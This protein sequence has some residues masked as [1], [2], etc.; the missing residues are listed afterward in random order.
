MTATVS[1]AAMSRLRSRSTSCGPKLTETFFNRSTGSLTLQAPGRG[2][3]PDHVVDAIREHAEHEVDGQYCHEGSDERLGGRPADAFGA[4][5]AVEAA[6]A[7]DQRG[8]AAED[9][10]FH[11][12]VEKIPEA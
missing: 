7:G 6:V 10:H 1:P 2:R 9:R 4:G 11:Q 3:R 12:A 8:D 5:L